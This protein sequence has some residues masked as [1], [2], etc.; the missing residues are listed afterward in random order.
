METREAVMEAGGFEALAREW[1]II[2]DEIDE[3]ESRLKKRKEKLRQVAGA[4][5]EWMDSAGVDGKITGAGT[6]FW[7]KDEL[8]AYFRDDETEEALAWLEDIGEGGKIKRTVHHKT[9]S[10][11]VG[12][13]L[14]EG[15]P[16]PE[17]IHYQIIPSLG[18]SRRRQS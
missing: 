4:I 18:T 16:L 6:T 2:R 12:R 5:R 11:L 14:D 9:L 13:L 15:T 3:I 8:R 17:C 7:P 10:S 1:R